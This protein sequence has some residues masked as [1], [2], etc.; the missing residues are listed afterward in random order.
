[1]ARLVPDFAERFPLSAGL[2][3]DDSDDSADGK[4]A[5]C[6][7]PQAGYRERAACAQQLR[8]VDLLRAGATACCGRRGALSRRAA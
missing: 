5:R 3:A 7:D 1:M 4:A 8:A 2:G 6:A